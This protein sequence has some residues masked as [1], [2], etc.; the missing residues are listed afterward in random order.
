VA[1]QPD[2][3][4]PERKAQELKTVERPAPKQM[5]LWDSLMLILRPDKRP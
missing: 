4:T 2:R 3:S 5:S 1:G